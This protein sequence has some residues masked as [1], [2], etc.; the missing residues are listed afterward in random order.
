MNASR[1]ASERTPSRPSRPTSSRFSR[2][3]SAAAAAPH[4]VLVS[5]DAAEGAARPWRASPEAVRFGQR[6][7][8]CI[9]APTVPSESATLK[10]KQAISRS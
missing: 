5:F 2:R 8:S 4:G 1:W 10:G 7:R 9:I 6:S 3:P